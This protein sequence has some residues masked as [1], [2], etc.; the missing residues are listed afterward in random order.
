MC[1]H[2][3]PV[4]DKIWQYRKA[5]KFVIFYNSQTVFAIHFRHLNA[6][7]WYRNFLSMSLLA[8]FVIKSERRNMFLSVCTHSRELLKPCESSHA[9]AMC[10]VHRLLRR[11]I[12]PRALWWRH[13]QSMTHCLHARFPTSTVHTRYLRAFTR[14][15]ITYKLSGTMPHTKLCDCVRDSVIICTHTLTHS[16]C[17]NDTAN[18]S[19]KSVLS[20]DSIDSCSPSC[21]EDTHIHASDA[22][23]N[24]ELKCN[25]C[26]RLV[27]T[28]T[29]VVFFLVSFFLF[30][31]TVSLRVLWL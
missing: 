24:L 15:C 30:D 13:G 26:P 22:H 21:D 6:V 29:I 4:R 25:F 12:A 11:L 14:I 8:R 28:Q 31:C 10:V 5:I 1:N 27:C 2:P 3:L 16:V 20:I 9:R 18:P 19:W 17:K 7:L 23:I